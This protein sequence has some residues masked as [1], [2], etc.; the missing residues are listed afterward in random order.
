LIGAAAAALLALL[1]TE[2]KNTDLGAHLFGFIFGI[3]LGFGAEFLID[4]NGRPGKILNSLLAFLSVL[5]VL[6]AWVYA[7]TNSG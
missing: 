4:L 2:G 3:A 7:I 6:I 1:G 5:I